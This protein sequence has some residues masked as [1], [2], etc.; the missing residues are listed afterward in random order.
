MVNRTA[1]M[2]KKAF[3]IHDKP[4]NEYVFYTDSLLFVN[5]YTNLFFD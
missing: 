4:E 2:R 3:P 5:M 1:R